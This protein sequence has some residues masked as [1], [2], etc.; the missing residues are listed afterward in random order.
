MI[1]ELIQSF[2]SIHGGPLLLAKII[3]L[4]AV[5]IIAQWMT[6][7]WMQRFAKRQEQSVNMLQAAD[8]SP[9]MKLV[10]EQTIRISRVRSVRN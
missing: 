8:V 5:V 6:G 7:H 2:E 4:L 3:L 10:H 9:E 1:S